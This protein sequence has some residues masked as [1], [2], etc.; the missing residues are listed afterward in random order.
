M[1]EI[2]DKVLEDTFTIYEARK[3]LRNLKNFLVNKLF[4]QGSKQDE[5]NQED[6]DF[7]NSLDEKFLS[8]FNKI[9]LYQVFD[10][11]E[12]SLNKISPLVIYLPFEIGHKE[13]FQ[14]GIW[15]RKNY[16]KNFLFEVKFDPSLIAGCALVWNG[17][18]KDYSL[19]AKIA[20]NQVQII[21][22]FKELNY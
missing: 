4:A 9:N 14:I 6:L 15:L 21:A 11:L 13:S 19:K 10:A 16:G 2:L 20:E 7:L 3:R 5:L 12:E 17:I 1:N 18:Y 22:K 8:N